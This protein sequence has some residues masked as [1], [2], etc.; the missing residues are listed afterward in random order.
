MFKDVWFNILLY[1]DPGQDLKS[2]I[3]VDKLYNS[4]LHDNYFWK[5]YYHQHQFILPQ[6]PYM[7]WIKSV[8]ITLKT[9]EYIHFLM[10]RDDIYPTI[11]CC[12]NHI[13]IIYS[14]KKKQFF[15]W[16]KY[17]ENTKS[18]YHL[19]DCHHLIYNYIIQNAMIEMFNCDPKKLN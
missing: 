14:I 7:N 13:N 2:S 15:S 19:I 3:C 5:Q 10:T 6:Q 16:L 8:D 9:N 1:M 18:Q 12:D 11:I 17:N 4:I